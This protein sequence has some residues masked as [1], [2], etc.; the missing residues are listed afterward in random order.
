MATMKD[1]AHD[2]QR[3]NPH[4]GSKADMENVIKSVFEIILERIAN[5][6]KVSIYGFGAFQAKKI[7]G[8]E[9]KSPL[10]KGGSVS[11]DDQLVLRFRQSQ[12]AKKKINK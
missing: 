8:R 9:V 10:V 5:G 11:F 2:V 6:E 1:I 4:L 3:D 12:G 7:A